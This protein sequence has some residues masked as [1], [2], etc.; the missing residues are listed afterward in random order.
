MD[1]TNEVKFIN[2]PLPMLQ[3][4]LTDSNAIDTILRYGVYRASLSIKPT[5][6][7]ACQQLLYMAGRHEEEVPDSLYDIV[8]EFLKEEPS[9]FLD[10]LMGDFEMIR[11][12]NLTDF[13][14]FCQ[15]YESDSEIMEWYKVYLAKNIIRLTVN[16]PQTIDTGRTIHFAFGNNN[17]PVSCGI[18]T[19]LMLRDNMQKED[20]RVKTAMYLAIRSLCGKGVAITTSKAIQWRMM[21]AKNEDELKQALKDK[22][23]KTVWEKWSSKRKYR[24]I[25]NELIASKM[26]L[27]TPYSHRTC[28]SASILDE[29]K[30][31]EAV[32][33][34]IRNI[35]EKR[36]S[37][38]AKLQRNKI[39]DMLNKEI[40][41]T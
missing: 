37:A 29:S 12:D 20:G 2:F 16:I 33:T 14:E 22:K 40:N 17:V 13:M 8:K 5:K 31:V 36:C 3:I 25:L 1:M 39:K 28:V 19:L 10:G 15:Q 34:K 9:E 7:E 4:V 27:E 30:F 11:E 38:T 41:M 6:N 24:A 23:I 18:D 35:N 26:I 32:A 21:G